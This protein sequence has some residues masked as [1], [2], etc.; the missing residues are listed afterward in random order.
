MS[1]YF[2]DSSALVKRYLTETGTNWIRNL[3]QPSIGNQIFVAQIASVE[4]VSALARKQR[5]MAISPRTLQAAILLIERHT[6]REYII[7]K[8]DASVER[9]AKRLLVN[10]PLRAYDA[11]QLA[12]ALFINTVLTGQNLPA[13]TF[14]CDDKRL[15]SVAQSEGVGTDDPSSH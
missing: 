4:M 10:Y 11:V 5:E 2:L 14:V 6:S 9:V 12:S 8:F 15:L 13:L 1:A 3:M 7:T